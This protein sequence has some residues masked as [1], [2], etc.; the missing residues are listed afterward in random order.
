VFKVEIFNK[1]DALQK[2]MC[3]AAAEAIAVASCQTLACELDITVLGLK[4]Y[5]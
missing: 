5:T 4:S 3:L 2:S 1:A